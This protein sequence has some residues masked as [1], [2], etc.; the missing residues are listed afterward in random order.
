MSFVDTSTRVATSRRRRRIGSWI[1]LAVLLAGV[2]VAMVAQANAE[3]SKAERA[4]GRTLREQG[5]Q[6]SLDGSPNMALVLLSHALE[7][8]PDD[9]MTRFLIA[10]CMERQRLQVEQR[11]DTGMRW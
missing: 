11:A 5:R 2:A 6:E 10:R 8:L 7:K 1:G 4:Q 3:A 9:K